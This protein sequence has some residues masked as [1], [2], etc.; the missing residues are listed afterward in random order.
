[1][2]LREARCH[3]KPGIMK[4][5][6]LGLSG[7]GKRTLFTLLTG[8]EVSPSRKPDE[9]VEGIAQIRDVRVDT[10]AEI[11]KPQRKVYAENSFVLCPDVVAGERGWLDAARR[12]N[13]ICLVVRAFD[14]DAVY[15]PAGSVD[16]ER[17]IASLKSELLLADM[18]I[19]E[20]RTVRLEKEKRSGLSSSQQAEARALEKCMSA[21]ESEQ[22]LDRLALDE[23][24]SGAIR[25]LE[26]VTTIPVLAIHNVSE[27]AIGDEQPEDAVCVSC[28]IEQEIMAI[29]DLEERQAFLSEM[30]L[31]ASGVDRVNEAAYHAQG[32]LS[33]YTTGADEVRAWTIRQG[34]LAPSA[35]GKVHTDIERG[36]IR[37][38]IVKYDD[39]MDAGSEKAAKE[40]GK[41]Q[42]KG[43]DYCIENGDIC[44]FLFNV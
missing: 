16:A 20:K 25:S 7:A 29:D 17:D 37:V 33:F 26:F 39:F 8:R 18:G 9:A 28:L 19:A 31:D 4:I 12:C 27:D 22:R 24:E 23:H 11:C 40:R 3:G 43:K 6:L 34:S 13:L 36:F 41:M 1:M 38:E 10:L 30:G 15:H 14:S 21:L 35:G 44:H 2:R 42:L 5:A 32:L